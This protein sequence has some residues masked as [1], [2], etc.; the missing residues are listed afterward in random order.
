MKYAIVDGVRVEAAK[1][2]NGTCPSCGA[3]VIAKCGEIRIDHW[4]HRGERNC[5]PWWENETEWHRSWKGL[6][7]ADWQEILHYDSSGEK[8]IADVKTPE[9]WVLE[10][11]HSFLDSS[12]RKSRNEFYKKIVW[13]VDGIRRKTDV[14]QFRT[15][16]ETGTQVSPNNPIFKVQF[17]EECR[18]V[19]EW[20]N[21]S[22]LTFFDFNEQTQD[23]DYRIWLLFPRLFDNTTYIAWFL[24][25]RFVEL[26]KTGS[27]QNFV[28]NKINETMQILRELN[29]KT[30]NKTVG[31][32]RLFVARSQTYRR[33]RRR[34]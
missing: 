9:N 29:N 1:G 5:D 11:Q 3:P 25:N 7:P 10:F 18:L 12:E 4:A 19:R 16:V 27:F 22:T 2:I 32:S 13:V 26:N 15:W 23:G 14:K 34:F 28:D 20:E 17:P 33:S 21:N 31:Y 6:F 30:R 24:R 8:H